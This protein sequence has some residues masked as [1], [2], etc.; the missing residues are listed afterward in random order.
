MHALFHIPSKYWI[1]NINFRLHF[2]SNFLYLKWLEKYSPASKIRVS[3]ALTLVKNIRYVYQP[4]RANN[5]DFKYFL[6]SDII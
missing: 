5:Y 2:N 4:T 3:H 6:T 1:L